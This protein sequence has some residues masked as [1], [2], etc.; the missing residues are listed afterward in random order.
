MKGYTQ[1]EIESGGATD[2][3]KSHPEK[4]PLAE[5]QKICDFCVNRVSEER[6]QG[7]SGVEAS[8][9]RHHKEPGEDEVQVTK[10]GGKRK[11]Q[12][13]IRK[14]EPQPCCTLGVDIRVEEAMAATETRLVGRVRGRKFT[15]DYIREWVQSEW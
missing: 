6:C 5:G 3:E 8:D 13:P 7:T 14:K 10:V 1:G 12:G 2:A 4:Q 9:G 11:K 15:A